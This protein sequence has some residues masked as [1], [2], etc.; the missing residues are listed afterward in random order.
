VVASIFLMSNANK[1]KRTVPDKNQGINQTNGEA[2]E[3]EVGKEIEITVEASEFQ[4]DPNVINIKKGQKVVLTFKNAG[5]I[6][7]DFIIDEFDVA[8]P[9]T[10]PG[11]TRTVEFTPN[12]AGSFSYY[13]NVSNHRQLGMEGVINVE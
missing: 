6:T 13:C 12:E 3:A 8:T 2:P 7:H 10:L 4:F 11:E 9:L 1:Q 5:T